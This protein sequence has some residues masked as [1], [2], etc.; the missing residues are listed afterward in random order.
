MDKTPIA[1]WSK[2]DTEL[3]YEGVRQF[4]TDLSLI[5]QLFPGRTRR[6]V[7]LKYKKEEREQPLRLSDALTNRAKDHSHFEAVIVRLQQIAAEENENADKDGSIELGD[8]DVTD[9]GIPN[10]SDVNDE[11][12]KNEQVEGHEKE[13]DVGQVLAEDGSP[14]KS[15]DSDDDLFR[16]SQYK[17][18]T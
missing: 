9:V 12:A 14:L 4:G 17:S 1:R 10:V 15:Y 16:W 2:Q 3:F 18:D 6:Q 5:Q 8:N 13:E 7:K 11:E